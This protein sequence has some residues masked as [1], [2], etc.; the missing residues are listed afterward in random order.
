M[1]GHEEKG[2]TERL[3][4]GLILYQLDIAMGSPRIGNLNQTVRMAN[5][6]KLDRLL[7][8]LKDLNEEKFT[9]SIKINFSQ[10]S[11]ARV[12]RFEEISKKLSHRKV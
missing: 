7:E 11:I 12:E 6:K 5:S 4:F 3:P 10:G 8:Y 2:P 1:T 9:G